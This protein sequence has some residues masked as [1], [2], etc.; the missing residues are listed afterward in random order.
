MV[1]EAECINLYSQMN[2]NME[3]VI[4]PC[5]SLDFRKIKNIASDAYNYWW[6]GADL[7]D[8]YVYDTAIG[9]YIIEQLEKKGGYV[10]G[11][12]Y[13]MYFDAEWN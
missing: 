1:F 4:I 10:L 8:E 9:D 5:N 11:K 3:V 13:K 6:F 7:E 2:D 12:H